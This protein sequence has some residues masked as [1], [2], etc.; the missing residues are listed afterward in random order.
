VQ[1]LTITRALVQVAEFSHSDEGEVG[2]MHG[3][4]TICQVDLELGKRVGVISGV[5][6]TKSVV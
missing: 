1:D 2:S 5:V 4:A 3:N 6:F